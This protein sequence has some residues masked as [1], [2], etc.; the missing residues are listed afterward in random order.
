MLE[1]LRTSVNSVHSK[2][3][4]SVLLEIFEDNFQG[5]FTQ[6]QISTLLNESG[7]S[8]KELQLTLLPISASYAIV[9]ISN[10]YVGAV[11]CGTSGKWYLGANFEFLGQG[12]FNSIHAEQSAISNAWLNGE[13]G[14]NEIIVNY[15][16]CG[17][18]RQFMNELT[19]AKNIQIILPNV[20][21]SLQAF[22]P[23]SFGP[24]DLEIKD[25]LMSAQNH[26]LKNAAQT[27]SKDSLKSLALEGMQKSY[28]PYSKSYSAVAL[29]FNDGRQICGRYAENAAFNPS[30]PPMQMAYSFAVLHGCDLKQIKRALLLENAKGLISQVDLTQVVLKSLG[31]VILEY[32][33][34]ECL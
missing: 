9:P 2:P 6:A 29:E 34:I 12:L 15:S 11:A 3:L 16:P 19:T 26:Q 24:A 30:L 21:S 31:S 14:V 8:T 7:L 10:F 32:E 20:Q 23:H 18:C 13:V 22:L 27:E 33:Q 17:H 28:A 25:A 5:F 4:K 1:N